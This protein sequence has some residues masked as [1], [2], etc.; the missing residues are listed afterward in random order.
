MNAATFADRTSCHLGRAS[1]VAVIGLVLSSAHICIWIFTLGR[2]MGAC[3][4]HDDGKPPG[5]RL[6]PINPDIN[7][8]T[9]DLSD[10]SPLSSAKSRSTLDTG[11][12]GMPEPE[13]EPEPQVNGLL[14]GGW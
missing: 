14:N 7:R 8:I 12:G 11:A 5:Q 9:L 6:P 1:E 2:Q 10:S 13:P 4:S 3:F